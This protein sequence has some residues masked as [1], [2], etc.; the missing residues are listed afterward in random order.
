MRVVSAAA[1][2]CYLTTVGTASAVEAIDRNTS[3]NLT[4]DALEQCIDLEGRS[5]NNVAT[6]FIPNGTY[7]VT[8][9]SNAEYQ[10]GV[11]ASR[12]DKV[13]FFIATFSQPKGWFFTVEEGKP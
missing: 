8:V 11:P 2:M 4:V 6:L 5:I 9:I 7:I 13:A 1:A 10:A 12:V 3:L